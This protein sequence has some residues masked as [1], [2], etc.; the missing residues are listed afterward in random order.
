[1]WRVDAGEAASKVGE[2]DEKHVFGQH[3]VTVTFVLPSNT[4]S[5]IRDLDWLHDFSKSI[6]GNS[7]SCLAIRLKYMLVLVI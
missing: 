7:Q 3:E 2:E 6:G 4:H 1:M 5:S